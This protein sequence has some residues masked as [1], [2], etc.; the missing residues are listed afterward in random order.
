MFTHFFTGEERVANYEDA[1]ACDTGA[2]RRYFGAMLE[3]GVYLAPSAFE[4]AFVSAVHLDSDLE[5]T[6]EAHR[7]VLD[8]LPD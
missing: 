7:A 1:T 4:A 8:L 6:V 5:Q 2:F 3:R